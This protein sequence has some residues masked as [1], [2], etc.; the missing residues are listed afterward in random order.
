M[1]TSFTNVSS[2]QAVRSM[3][4]S[5][6]NSENMSNRAVIVYKVSGSKV[7]IEASSKY[8]PACIIAV[9]Y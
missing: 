1:P 7:K 2:Y 4:T 9:G 5:S 8:T 6:F 3:N